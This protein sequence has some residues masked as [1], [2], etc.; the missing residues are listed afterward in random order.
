MDSPQLKPEYKQLI[1]NPENEV[2]V[3]TASAWEI[4][5]KKSVGKIKIDLS[6]MDI[7]T[8][9]GFKIIDI[10]LPHIE[11]LEKLPLLHKDPFDR[12]LIAQANFENMSLVTDDPQIKRYLN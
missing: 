7:I 4:A 10:A 1:S 11:E 9:S 2:F 6:A 5:I 8:T 12:I 3:S